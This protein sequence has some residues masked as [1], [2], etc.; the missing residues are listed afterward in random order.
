MQSMRKWLGLALT[1][2]ACLFA[3]G[4]QATTYNLGYLI[5]DVTDTVGFTTSEFDVENVTG[6]NE[7]A[8][9]DTTDFPVTNT[10]AFDNLSLLVDF[11]DGSSIRYPGSS[12]TANLDGESWDGPTIAISSGN[13]QPTEAILTGTFSP[14]TLALFGGGSD[15][16]GAAFT[17]DMDAGPNPLTGNAMNDNLDSVLITASSAVRTVPEPGSLSLLVASLFGLLLFG[18][19]RGRN[20]MRGLFRI[21]DGGS[22]TALALLTGVVLF[23]AASWAQIGLTSAA[24]PS[25]G[26]SGITSVTLTASGLPVTATPAG[27]EVRMSQVSCP[28][29]ASPPIMN[30]VDTTAFS[31]KT[32]VGITKAVQFQ[33]PAS[34][35][36]GTYY[37]AIQGSSFSS[38]DCSLVMVTHGSQILSSCVPSSSLAL[39]TGT[40]VTAYV[41]NGYWDG[42]ASGLT[43]VNVEGATSATPIATGSDLINACSANSV[44][45]R[46]VC[47]ANNTDVYVITGT[48]VNNILTSG[49]N[50]HGSFSGG[51]CQNCGVA[52]N[53]LTNT[54]IISGGFSG[55]LSGDGVQ[56]LNLNSS[57]PTF[58]PPFPM[59]T[60]V[61]ENIS[62]DPLHSL[63][64]TPDEDNS[65]TLLKTNPSGVPT[66]EYDNS[67]T[68]NSA[69][70]D[71]DSGEED[72]TTE[73]SYAPLEFSASYIYLVDLSQA[74]FPPASPAGTWTGPGQ[75]QYI[76][77][78]TYGGY[79]AGPSGGAVAPG[80]THLAVVEGEFGGNTFA[81]LKLPSTSGSGTPALVDYAMAQFPPTPD[82]QAFS[83]GFDPH[84]ITAYT[85]PNNG[86]AYAVAAGYAGGVGSVPR[87]VG[88]VDLA[89]L[90]AEPRVAGD[91]N[92]VVPT[93]DLVADG[94]I[95]YISLA[96]GVSG[97]GGITACP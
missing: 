48:T 78:A 64:I 5:Y 8:L 66:A 23:P 9:G 7:V 19:S 16:V 20:K 33:I 42:G 54:A 28:D 24:V 60:T 17:A 51:S 83:A 46:T 18:G 12:F 3:A 35:P 70:G 21:L 45:G 27:T 57:P 63:V 6:P 4:A 61:S 67:V 56:A 47:T 55:G 2:T 96:T 37:V 43:A 40:T 93:K 25:S 13:P 52:I 84:T 85:I 76:G 97:G 91:P 36:T 62:I 32:V 65:Y 44:T 72:C 81:A 53:A 90:L 82:C 74:K 95:R 26:V 30:E 10:I 49:A 59:N 75:D 38:H 71:M 92:A 14:T 87:W 88:V 77:T 89:A 58:D 29:N 68:N 39:L 22:V 69:G 86:K 15:T 73:I 94:T 80:S 34:T 50:S 79:S 41:P 31:I 11:S 1:A